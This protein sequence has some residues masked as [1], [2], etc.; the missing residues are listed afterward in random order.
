[1]GNA[2]QEAFF[3]SYL[4]TTRSRS[5]DFA[6]YT[7]IPIVHMLVQVGMKAMSKKPTKKTK[8]LTKSEG[9]TEGQEAYYGS[10]VAAA[11]T[12]QGQDVGTYAAISSDAQSESLKSILENLTPRQLTALT[13]AS[14]WVLGQDGAAFNRFDHDRYAT[15]HRLVL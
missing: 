11:E 13:V 15:L 12:D 9:Q 7:K 6:V 10:G 2:T 3:N 14:R 8:S 5:D 4:Q 1:V